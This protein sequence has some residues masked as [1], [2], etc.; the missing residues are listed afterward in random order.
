MHRV[1]IIL[2]LGFVVGLNI[3]APL[4]GSRRG[5]SKIVNPTPPLSRLAT[6]HNVKASSALAPLRAEAVTT[7]KKKFSIDIALLLYFFFWYLGNYYYNITNK[8]ALNAAGGANGFPVLI[9]ALQLFVG[10]IYAIFLWVAPDSRKFPTVNFKDIITLLPVAFCAAGAHSASVF[11]LSAGAVSFGQIVKAAEPAFAA[12]LGTLFYNKKISKAKWLC[13]IPVIGGV[14]LASVKELDFAVSALISASIANLFAAVKAN[15]NKKCMDTPGLKERIGSVGNQY[16][17]TTILAT[18]ITIPLIF[19]KGEAAKIGQFVTL[20]Q[21]NPVVR[22]NI[23]ASGLYFYLYNELATLTIKKTSAVTQSVANTA[24]RVIV[25]VG[26]ALV[27]GESLPPLKLLG[28]TIGIGGVF[29]YSLADVIWKPK[30]K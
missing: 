12:V 1:G 13:L 28:C 3:Q 9:S 21:D 4:V 20:F 16:A 25:I 6:H 27:L 22:F 23:L 18:L 11:A 17:L 7:E 19:V 30:A 14:V 24:K 8:L 26:V 2:S 5:V 15:E 10:S 29:L